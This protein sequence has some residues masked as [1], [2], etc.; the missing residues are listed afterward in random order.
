M[1]EHDF[2]AL[3]GDV[4]E[5]A[6]ANP[7]MIVM[8]RYFDR[9]EEARATTLEILQNMGRLEIVTVGDYGHEDPRIGRA[10]DQRD[11]PDYSTTRYDENG[12]F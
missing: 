10:E 6:A 9:A 1:D 7:H 8:A 11:F 12:P 2:A 5:Y 3:V 4:A